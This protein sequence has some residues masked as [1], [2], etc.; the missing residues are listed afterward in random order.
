M[1]DMKSKL[2][3]LSDEAFENDALGSCKPLS[4][5]AE[6]RR[7]RRWP[8]RTFLKHRLLSTDFRLRTGYSNDD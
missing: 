6:K 5:E 8:R 3:P 7:R 2:G 1:T 4:T